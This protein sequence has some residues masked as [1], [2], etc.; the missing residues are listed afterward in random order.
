MGLGVRQGPGQ[1]RARSG[2]T[3]I[4]MPTVALR[5]LQTTRQD[6]CWAGRLLNRPETTP[7][8]VGSRFTW[9]CAEAGRTDLMPGSAARVT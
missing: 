3:A 5:A 2:F 9:A 6:T 4:S 7:H 8:R 1:H